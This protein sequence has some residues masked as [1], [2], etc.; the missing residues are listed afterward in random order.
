MALNYT[1]DQNPNTEK[2]KQSYVNAFNFKYLGTVGTN[3]NDIHEE[4]INT[5]SENLLT[6]RPEEFSS[7]CSVHSKT[8]ML[9]YT[10]L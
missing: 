4:T 2:G 3:Q 10:N 1:A 9:K 6:F 5:E 8:K 7:V